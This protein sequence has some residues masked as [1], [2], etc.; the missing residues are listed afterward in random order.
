MRRAIG[1]F[2]FLGF[3]AVLIQSGSILKVFIDIP[4]LVFV[5]GSI[6]ALSVAKFSLSEIRSFSDEVVMSLINFSLISGAI[7]FTVGIVQLL[8]NLSDPARLGPS[9]AVCLLTLF[10]S[11]LIAAGLFA[12]RGGI[13][14]KA[15]GGSA[16]AG[17]VAIMMAMSML[18]VS[19]V[20]H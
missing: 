12:I 2:S 8:L 15:I 5:L 17:S 4:S 11:L 7:G 9:M 10:Y 19:F 14:H 6:T 13:K 16:V 3:V 20:G 1:L 18:L